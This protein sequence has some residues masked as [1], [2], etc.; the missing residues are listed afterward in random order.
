VKS[1]PKPEATSHIPLPAPVPVIKLR[2]VAVI[3]RHR[4]V[5][6]L[7]AEYTPIPTTPLANQIPNCFAT[8]SLPHQYQSES[9]SVHCHNHI[10]HR[11]RSEYTYSVVVLS[12][13]LTTTASSHSKSTVG[14]PTS[15]TKWSRHQNQT[16]QDGQRKGE[17]HIGSNGRVCHTHS[18]TYASPPLR[19]PHARTTRPPHARLTPAPPWSQGTS[20]RTLALPSIALGARRPGCQGVS[21]TGFQSG[22]Q[23]CS[24]RT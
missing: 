7:A 1:K 18:H 19:P 17:R 5:L 14:R 23:G 4:S 13:C 20:Q 24:A 12:L 10:L 2:P 3:L 22:S 8:R 21:W 11:Q 9:S 16:K 15:E 6:A